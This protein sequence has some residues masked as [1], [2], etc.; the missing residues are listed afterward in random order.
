[1]SLFSL[2]LACSIEVAQWVHH[3]H[4]GGFNQLL[5]E[6][7]R[8]MAATMGGV[9]FCSVSEN[10]IVFDSTWTYQGRLCYDRVSSLYRAGDGDLWIT[11]LGGGIEVFHPDGSVTGYGQLEGLP[12]NLMVN[13]VFPDSVVYAA[14]TQGLAIKT[15]GYFV[16]YN[17]SGTGGGL[18]SSVVNCL[19]P[20]DSGLLV[21]T[22][23]GLALLLPGLPPS[24]ASSWR[25]VEPLAGKS[26]EALVF[27]GDSLWSIASGGVYVCPPGG[28]W[29]QMASY[30]GTSPSSLCAGPSG[31]TVGDLDALHTFSGGGWTSVEGEFLGNPVTAVAEVAGVGLVAG[32]THSI[33]VDRLEGTGLALAGPAGVTRYN[34]PG[35]IFNDVVSVGVTGDGACW[36]GANRSGVAYLSGDDWTR[37]DYDVLPA[38]NQVFALEA[39]GATVYAGSHSHGITWI[40]WDGQEPSDGITF[41]KEDGLI[42]DQV[43]AVSIWNDGTAWFAQRPF[44]QSTEPSGVCRL[45]W[46]PGDPETAVISQVTGS[47]GMPNRFV[48]DIEA[49]AP[50]TAYAA[51]EAGLAM[52]VL[53]A[54]VPRVYTT[55][56]GLP[57][58]Y[59]ASVVVTRS[60]DVFAGTATGLAVIRNGSVRVVPEVT[61]FVECLCEDHLGGVWAGV[62]GAL[63]RIGPD[64]EVQSFTRYNSPLPEVDVRNMACD[65]DRGR[66]WLATSHGVWMADLGG[67]LHQGNAG[68]AVYPNP[69]RPGAGEVLGVAGIPDEPAVFSVFDLGGALVHRY[70]SRGRDDF[71]WNGRSTDGSPAPSGIYMLMIQGEGGMEMFKFTLVR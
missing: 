43:E 53:P 19:A 22:Y 70:D 58:S 65:P 2:V 38:N 8:V 26:V 23:S 36:V 41:T 11:Y 45:T 39:S 66:L 57:S 15:L 56:D 63:Y 69:F 28:G 68:A 51:T 34:P 42:N 64:G 49:V 47:Q 32:I 67:G 1:M 3:P 71:A 29:E 7:G 14:T 55:A 13:Q 21:G 27:R 50:D 12:L 62:P 59:V 37:L 48:W 24:E 16:N 4:F 9:L 20:V 5:E 60:G 61:G 25:L 17:Q 44:Q 54:G 30:P 35:G 18:P 10:G 52:V 31:V 6:D 46:E 33:S 40:H